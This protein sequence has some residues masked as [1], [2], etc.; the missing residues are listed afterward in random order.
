ML[1]LD[2]IREIGVVPVIKLDSPEQALPLAGALAK[3]GV[4][5]AEVTLPPR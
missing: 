3:G 1:L 4:P 5:V 2:R